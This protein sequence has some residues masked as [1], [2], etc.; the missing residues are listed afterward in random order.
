M[1]IS[2]ELRDMIIKMMLEQLEEDGFFEDY[3]G[4]VAGMMED[5][6][7]ITEIVDEKEAIDF[8]NEYNDDVFYILKQYYEETGEPYWDMGSVMS[9]ASLTKFMVV[10]NI[11]R[12]LEGVKNDPE[13]YLAGY[14]K[15][16]IIEE[17]E[18]ML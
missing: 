16:D 14:T 6:K 1:E 2:K 11:L 10:N 12:D 9:V 15:T 8:I 5:F 17:L 7:M 4:T 18:A 3:S 13:A